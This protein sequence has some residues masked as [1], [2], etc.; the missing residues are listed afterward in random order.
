M[1][2]A[3]TYYEHAAK[4]PELDVVEYIPAPDAEACALRIALTRVTDERNF[5]RTRA[6]TLEKAITRAAKA[7]TGAQPR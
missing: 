7:T 1:S 4:A 2:E 6:Q 3:P 5:W